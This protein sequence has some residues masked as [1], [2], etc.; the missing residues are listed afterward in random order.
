LVNT[1]FE[2]NAQTAEPDELPE[3][4]SCMF[5]GTIFLGDGFLL[6][7][8]EATALTSS[9]ANQTRI[10][11]LLNGQE[12]NGG[13]DQL[14]SRSI[15]FLEE[16]QTAEDLKATCPE[17]F[18]RVN[19]LV[20]PE[21][22]AQKNESAKR[23][24]WRYYRYNK[25]CYAQLEKLQNGF[26]AARTTK[27][28]SFSAISKGQIF[29]DAVYVFT[30]DRWD[31]YAVVQSTIHEVWARKYSG[32]LET[33]LRYSPSDCFETFAFPAGQWQT[34]NTQL[35]DIGERYHEHR[36]VLMLQ[37][38]LG[39]TDI[40]NLFHAP[41]LEAR[42]ATLYQ[43]RSASRTDWRSEVPEEH[44][45]TAG[46]LTPEQAR[47]AILELRTLHRELDQ[48]VLTAYGWHQDSSDGPAITLGHNF[49]EVETLPENDRTR[50]TISPQARKDLLTRLL[51][52]NHQRAD[53][54]GSGG[55]GSQSN[56]TG[57]KGPK[58]QRAKSIDELL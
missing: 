53:E 18:Q 25:D 13:P 32:A 33:R 10:F 42:L 48:T 5:M 55:T 3:N 46:S 20:L 30:T 7:K 37:L 11:P 50:Y 49:H 31:H 2:D 43:R 41:D 4:A 35:A 40:Y 56:A 28:L 26:A 1:H 58:P 27:H 15:I 39:L 51:T 16:F 34:A 22:L 9:D 44:R 24:W 45:T 17:L 29:T 23:K 14:A 19:D 38:W 47:D 8:D 21:R 12:L 6:N 57:P 36:R 54:E 52:L